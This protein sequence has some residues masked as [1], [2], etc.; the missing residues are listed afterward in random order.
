MQ[1]KDE[2]GRIT[3]PAPMSEL[4]RNTLWIQL[5]VLLGWAWFILTVFMLIFI[6]RNDI[7]T[8]FVNSCM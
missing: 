4:T 1:Y 8:H 5:L 3:D 6:A 2:Q 7:F